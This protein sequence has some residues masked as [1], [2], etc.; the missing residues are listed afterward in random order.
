MNARLGGEAKYKRALPS[1]LFGLCTCGLTQADQSLC[2]Q[3]RDLLSTLLRGHLLR[4]N[5]V[6]FLH[7]LR[8]S[9]SN[10]VDADIVR[11]TAGR[12]HEGVLGRCVLQRTTANAGADSARELTGLDQFQQRASGLLTDRHRAERYEI[13]DVQRGQLLRQR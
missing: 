3:E 4:R 7:R 2:Q 1:P 6:G 11:S 12:G 8:S 13:H 10:A 5:V 9:L